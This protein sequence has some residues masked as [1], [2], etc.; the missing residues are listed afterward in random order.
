ME[1]VKTTLK[2]CVE[3][4]INSGLED[5]AA[6][7]IYNDLLTRVKDYD[8]ITAYLEDHPVISSY[9]D[10]LIDIACDGDRAEQ[11]HTLGSYIESRLEGRFVAEGKPDSRETKAE[12]TVRW[13]VANSGLDPL[14]D[15]EI[16][17]AGFITMFRI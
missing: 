16:V 13:F 15:S 5:N 3:T 17:H 8:T 6:Y 14:A 4:C 9:S 10:G 12:R 2:Y 7:I 1:G 11:L